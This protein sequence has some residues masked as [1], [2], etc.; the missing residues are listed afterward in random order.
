MHNTIGTFMI[1]KHGE[2]IIITNNQ[3]SI[4]ILLIIMLHCILQFY[5][6]VSRIFH[7]LVA[8][9][10]RETSR[11]PT[12]IFIMFN[13]DHHLWNHWELPSGRN[14]SYT[15]QDKEISSICPIIVQIE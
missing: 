1:V 4:S 14:V 11:P 3:A 7:Q 6:C 8:V 2:S 12:N 13:F 9:Q 15:N 5:S 10:T